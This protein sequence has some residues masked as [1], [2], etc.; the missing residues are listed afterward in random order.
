MTGGAFKNSSNL[1]G[2]KRE[3][4]EIAERIENTKKL[5]SESEKRR[6]ALIKERDA[7]K[8]R[9][10]NLARS[11]SELSISM[12]TYSLNMEQAEKRL[13]DITKQYDSI[14]REK[15]ELD[16]QV[17]EI[18]LNKEELLGNNKQQEEAIKSLEE[19]IEELENNLASDKKALEEA[20]DN[21]N[22]YNIDFNTV[23]QQYDF[24]LQNVQRVKGE[25][26]NINETI[27][28]LKQKISSGSNEMEA[29][30]VKIEELRRFLEEN[31]R[32]IG[33]KEQKLTEITEQKN[34]LNESHKDFFKK[35]EELSEQING[36]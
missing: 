19:R 35:R 30:T 26:H 4:D 6:A 28:G 5:L 27:A 25:E 7:L 12:N 10:E 3:L 2:R 15:A 16:T 34:A 14:Q 22:K 13:G 32:I 18:N 33:I 23:K 36:F 1:L 31:N 8:E 17:K 24:V 21:I 9:K 29:L 11:M 20:A